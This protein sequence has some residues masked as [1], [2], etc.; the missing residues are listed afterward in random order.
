MITVPAFLVFPWIQLAWNG[1]GSIPLILAFSWNY[2]DYSSSIP[3][4]SMDSADLEWQRQH[5]S[6]S[7]IQLDI[8]K[9]VAFL[10][11]LYRWNSMDSAGISG[12][13]VILFPGHP[14]SFA[15]NFVSGMQSFYFSESQDAI[16]LQTCH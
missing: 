9:L 6:N 8:Q 11:L 14:A 7:C 15:H 16:V 10:V 4:I 12:S 1:R 2:H 3:C 13:T 5:S